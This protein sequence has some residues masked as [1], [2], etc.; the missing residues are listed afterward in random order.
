MARNGE[1]TEKAKDKEGW[2]EDFS[3]PAAGN[4]S[5]LPMK[6]PDRRE[7]DIVSLRLTVGVDDASVGADPSY[8]VIPRV[9]DV[10]HSE[11]VGHHVA[12]GIQQRL[13]CLATVTA[14]S[15]AH[16]LQACVWDSG[17]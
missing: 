2:Q 14:V 17:G 9:G 11:A 4:T 3:W 10:E 13:R 8:D 16:V 7:G 5:R 12:G 1:A 15:C 6:E